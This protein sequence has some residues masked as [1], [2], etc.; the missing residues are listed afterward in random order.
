MT[1]EFNATISYSFPREGREPGQQTLTASS[2]EDLLKKKA[3]LDKLGYA[4]T[5]E[6]RRT[7]SQ[8]ECLQSSHEVA[9]SLYDVIRP[10]MSTK[11]QR[12]FDARL[13]R[14]VL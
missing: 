1:T 3:R 5:I 11:R 10:M 7:P 8:S 4:Y 2:P 6:T 9:L 14:L 13:D 12:Y